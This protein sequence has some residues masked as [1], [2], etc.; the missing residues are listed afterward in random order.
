[1]I[2]QKELIDDIEIILSQ[3]N[4]NYERLLILIPG[5]GKIIGASRFNE[6]QNKLFEVGIGSVSINFNGV[7]GSKG[8]VEKD[9]LQGRITT[10]LKIINWVKKNLNFKELSLYGVSMGG[11]IVLHVQ[12][13]IQCNGKLII[14]TPASY[15]KEALDVN[16]DNNFTTILRTPNSWK[17]SESFDLLKQILN[18]V[19]LITHT[20]D[21][22]IPIEISDT[23]KDI[24]LQKENSK[25]IKIEGAK[26]SIWQDDKTLDE[27]K[28]IATKEILD[29][30]SL[31]GSK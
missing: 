19:L 22:V 9:S 12:N 5:G 21:E 16:F 2:L 7:E 23:Y 31:E 3:K 14:H 8:C 4:M 17:N 18:P 27:V 26:H 29:F 1:M 11:P 6:L 25:I 15:A 20:N 10:T 28:G 30:I 24:I 13:Q